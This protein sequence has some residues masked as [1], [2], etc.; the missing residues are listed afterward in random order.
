M[1]LQGKCPTCGIP[2][3]VEEYP[4][5]VAFVVD[6]QAVHD[7]PKCGTTLIYAEVVGQSPTMEEAQ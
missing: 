1:E 7:C 3:I 6:G 4:S 5:N 2:V